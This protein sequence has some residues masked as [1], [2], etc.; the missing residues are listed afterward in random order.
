MY[1]EY[2][3]FP[4]GLSH[5]CRGITLS[6]VVGDLL[7][8]VILHEGEVLFQL[9]FVDPAVKIDCSTFRGGWGLAGFIIEKLQRVG[10]GEKSGTS[11]W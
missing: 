3:D 6:E 5:Q 10:V 2:N 1:D 4:D 8:E 11:I 7:F 9:L